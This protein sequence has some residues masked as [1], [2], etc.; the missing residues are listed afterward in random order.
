MKAK[1]AVV[2]YAVSI[3]NLLLFFLIIGYN[4][5]GG[6]HDPA[7]G[8]SSIIFGAGLAAFVV[9]PFYLCLIPQIIYLSN[10]E[11]IKYKIKNVLIYFTIN[12]IG[13]IW[14][15]LVVVFNINIL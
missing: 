6:I 9:C 12:V 2:A 13:L 15:L 5:I 1:L 10:Y 14:V 8:L 4:I 7:A 3:L 11:E